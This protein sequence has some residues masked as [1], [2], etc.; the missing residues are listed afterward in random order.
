MI[1][2]EEIR[3]S[4]AALD[5][6]LAMQGIRGEICLFGG[7]V[8]VL[9]FHARQSTK[10][11]D[12]IFAPAAD[13]RALAARVGRDRG[14]EEDWINDGVKSFVSSRA[15]FVPLEL[16][17]SNLSVL[18]PVPEYLL[19]MKCMAARTGESSRDMEDAKFLIRHL[20]LDSPET[21]LTTVEAYYPAGRIT[22]KTRYFVEAAFEELASTGPSVA[23]DVSPR[24]KDV[25]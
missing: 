25:S 6:A 23:A 14:L 4:L 2:E 9:A 13:I 17:F 19:A 3:G 10:D 24:Q 8:M 11:V 7:A 16:Q 21:V 18:M 15:S 5:R 20:G 1:T 12:A 22:P